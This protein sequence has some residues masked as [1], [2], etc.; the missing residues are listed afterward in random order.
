MKQPHLRMLAREGFFFLDVV[1]L[2]LPFSSPLHIKNII[3][4]KF[5]QVG[6]NVMLKCDYDLQHDILYSIKWYKDNQEF[7]RYVPMD[8]PP[9]QRFSV[10]GA[11]TRLELSDKEHVHLHNISL[12]SAGLYT[13][14]VS[15][16][17]PRFRT[18]AVTMNMRVIHPP[19]AGPYLQGGRIGYRVGDL[20]D[21]NCSSPASHP[22]VLLKFYLNDEPVNEKNVLKI[23]LTKAKD[24]LT[25][26]LSS[27]TLRIKRMHFKHGSLT[28]KCTADIYRTY[29]KSVKRTFQGI[30]LGEKALGSHFLGSSSKN[31]PG[32]MCLVLLLVLSGKLI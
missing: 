30:D 3:V 1:F 20:L 21:V 18:Q 22:K 5:T 2:L 26:A 23:D 16:E 10:I 19:E 27:Y 8:E 17:A 7:Y 29:Y 15:T 6:E 4:P 14:E 12:A 9:K 11:D 32:V 24:G 25:P 28:L 13:C 31:I